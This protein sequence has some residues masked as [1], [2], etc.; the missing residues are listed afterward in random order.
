MEYDSHLL[1]PITEGGHVELDG[2]FTTNHGFS[3]TP[4]VLVSLDASCEVP[5]IVC[6]VQKLDHSVRVHLRVQ[7][8][9]TATTSDEPDFSTIIVNTNLADEVCR[10]NNRIRWTFWKSV[11]LLFLNGLTPEIGCF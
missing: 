9:S 2:I 11:S 7:R 5:A 4:A 8:K 6:D 10:S 3:R 1:I